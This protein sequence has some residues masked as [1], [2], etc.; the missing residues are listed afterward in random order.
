MTQFDF[1]QI[2]ETRKQKGI[3]MA[4]FAQ[5][6][7]VTRA[8]ISLYETGQREPNFAIFKRIIKALDLSADKI[9]GI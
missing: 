8:A 2:R 9:L 1:Q 6:I 3:S 5:M 7:G 4:Q